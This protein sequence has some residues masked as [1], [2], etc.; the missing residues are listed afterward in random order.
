MQK[1]YVIALALMLGAGTLSAQQRG[2]GRR[3]SVEDR[4]AEMTKTLGLS[5]DQ[6]KKITAIYTEF[7]SKRKEG[8]RPSR[9]EMMAKQEQ[10]DKQINALL[11]DEQKKK[12]EE[13]AKARQ[14]RRNK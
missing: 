14:P 3:M 13:M 11:T 6:Q 5:E 8:T 9:E 10:M 4:V 7:E 1:I 12:Y 2:G